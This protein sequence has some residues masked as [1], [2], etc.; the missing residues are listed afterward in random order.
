MEQQELVW[1]K[2]SRS[3]GNGD[4]CVEVAEQPDR[5]LLRDSKLGDT[6]PVIAVSRHEFRRLI[7]SLQ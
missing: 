3:G 6:S 1:R 2:S 7:V 4:N 5:V